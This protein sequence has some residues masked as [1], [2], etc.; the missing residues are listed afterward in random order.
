M[1]IVEGTHRVIVR[2]TKIPYYFNINVT[3]VGKGLK[4]NFNYNK[5]ILEE[6]KAME[7]RRWNP[8][9]KTWLINDSPRN[10]FAFEYLK[11]GNPYA[12]WE[13]EVSPVPTR[14]PLMSQQK[15]MFYDGAT[16]RHC[17]WAAEMGTGKTLACFALMEYLRLSPKD[18]GLGWGGECWYVGTKSSIR[19]LNLE[20]I[21]W[22]PKVWFHQVLTYDGLKKVLASWPEG[23]P[24]PRMIF[25]DESSKIK[26]PTAQRSECAKKIADAIHNEYGLES[27]II[28]MSGTPAP[29]APTDWHHQCIHGDS[30]IHTIDGPRRVKDLIGN[31]TPLFV[32][33]SVKKTNTGAFFKGNKKCVKILT[34]EGYELIATEDHLV[35]GVF[36]DFKYWTAISNLKKG[37]KI[38][39]NNHTGAKWSGRG[40]FDQGYL[41]GLVVGDGYIC[42]KKQTVSGYMTAIVLYT[43]NDKEL[44]QYILDLCPI[45]SPYAISKTTNCIRIENRWLDGLRKSFGLDCSKKI[46]EEMLQAS[47]LF[48]RGFL[49]GMFDT[50]GTCE[51]FRCRVQLAQTDLVRLKAIQQMLLHLG[52]P[53]KIVKHCDARVNVIEG[54]NVHSKQAW[55]LCVSGTHVKTFRDLIGFK[56]RHKSDAL[57]RAMNIDSQMSQKYE[58]EVKEVVDVGVQDVYDISVPE[59]NHFSADNFV[60]H[61]CEVAAP[62]FLKEGSV[63]DMQKRLALVI[64]KENIV[65]G[66]AY[67]QL[68]TWW[69][70]D[71]KCKTCGSFETFEKLGPKGE[72][73]GKAEQHD[74]ELSMM[75][76]KDYHKYE[77]SVN[78]VLKLYSR[79]QGLVRVIHKKDCMDLPEK[80][81]KEIELT[82]SKETLRA[83]KLITKISKTTMQ[84]MVRLR[85]LSDGFQYQEKKTGLQIICPVCAG[86]KLIKEGR[87]TKGEQYDPQRE[88]IERAEVI[89][90]FRIEQ[91]I[92]EDEFE[93]LMGD[94]L[95]VPA[96][97]KRL[98]GLQP[99]L[100]SLEERLFSYV[101]SPCPECEAT[102]L[103]DEYAREAVQ[104]PT[105]KED[106][107]IEILEDH[108]DIGRC[109]AYAGFTGSID[110][111]CQI[112]KKV[113]WETIR[114]DGRGVQASWPLPKGI[115]PVSGEKWDALAVFQKL[116]DG[117][118]R[119]LFVGHPKA[120]SMGITLTASPTIVY[121]SNDFDGEG[122]MQSEDR[123]HRKSMDLCKGAT[124]I[125]LLHLPA[126]RLVLQNLKKKYNLQSLSLGVVRSS[127]E[128]GLDE[129]ERR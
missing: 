71:R 17:I 101:D 87:N 102:G 115:D 106:A 76:G 110:R 24:A 16:Y 72:K 80:M 122:R 97:A 9:D 124:I 77:P 83:A 111:V 5:S 65:T 11:G 103:V 7:G 75:T 31:F 53:S 78:E 42:K 50:D 32:N 91:G 37:S 26:N 4:L 66:A 96:I 123:I 112:A 47:S 79:M 15:V 125:D 14:F 1:P 55:T 88:G 58:A 51:D 95:N 89:A 10:Q 49:S 128:K 18:A 52:I 61:N 116:Q 107:L 121:W 28:L 43:E 100:N 45:D 21:K 44:L 40:T 62:G 48:Y 60:V 64:Q 120:C 20:K 129:A 57:E 46:T 92:A 113:G 56:I 41:L 34:K 126:D 33:G 117:P 90:R 73:I 67:P 54:R 70:D 39:L 105:P 38:A 69:D 93:L 8:A 25:F 22:K 30:W 23:K 99:L 118:E 63:V 36:E 12:N 86:T 19:A 74:P 27:A 84:M 108:E 114:F 2:D 98:E 29:K 81:Y 59:G 82:P 127:M 94:E 35:Q 104:V 85:E 6:V 13:K 109:V 119:I 3:K 68:V